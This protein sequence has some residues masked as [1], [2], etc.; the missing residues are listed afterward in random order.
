MKLFPLCVAAL[1]SSTLS[2][3]TEMQE[4]T[5]IVTPEAALVRLL[6]GNERFTKDQLLSPDR[7]QDRRAATA[8]RQQPFAIIVGCSDSRVPPEVIFDQGIGDLFV[9][10]VAGN[11]VGPLELDSIEFSVLVNNSSIILVLGHQN[12]GAVSA[13]LSHNSRD[14]KAV[15]A[16]IEPAIRTVQENKGSLE[17]AVKANVRSVVDNLSRI[18]I[19][20]EPIKAGRLIIVGGYYNL[21]SGKV[22]ILTTEPLALGQKVLSEF[23]KRE[24]V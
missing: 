3:K 1:F 18:E 4:A 16:L 6:E 20:Q 2:A 23:Q 9:V 8:A 7:S 15:A 12:C 17:A 10:R 24:R 19:F 13:V 21:V 14:I 5:T 22:E 11:V